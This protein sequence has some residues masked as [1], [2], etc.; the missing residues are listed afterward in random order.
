MERLIFVHFL[1][2]TYLVQFKFSLSSNKDGATVKPCMIGFI[3]DRLITDI[4]SRKHPVTNVFFV[5]SRRRCFGIRISSNN[6]FIS[7]KFSLLSLGFFK[8]QY[9][10]IVSNS[11]TIFYCVDTLAPEA[12]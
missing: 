11:K 1:F 7:R 10:K 2:T 4:P 8:S 3:D 6:A 5:I 12:R 9:S